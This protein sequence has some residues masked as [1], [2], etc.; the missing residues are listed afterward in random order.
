MFIHYIQVR[1]TRYMISGG[2]RLK[3]VVHVG[4]FHR[5]DDVR[6]LKK[7]CVSLQETG[8]YEIVYIT[9]NRNCNIKTE[10]YNGIKIEVLPII[11]R[12]FIRLF[13]YIKAVYKKILAEKPEVCHIH[14]FVLFPLIKKLSKN[15]IKIILDLHENDVEDRSEQVTKKFGTILGKIFHKLILLYEKKAVLRSDAV[16]SVTPQIIDRVEVYGKPTALIPNYPKIIGN[17]SFKEKHHKEDGEVNVCF[18]GVID[19]IW[20]HENILKAL[21][22]IDNISFLL[23]GRV[24]KQYL[25][26]L[27]KYSAWSK[28]HYYGV[29]SHEDVKKEIYAKS[30]IGLALLKYGTGWLG[31][32][33]TLGNTKLFEYMEAGISIICTDFKIWHEII[34]K[35]NCGIM[36]D[37]NNVEEIKNAIITLAKNPELVK[38]MGENGRRAINRQY[39][40]EIIKLELIKLYEIVLC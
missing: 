23:A 11:N 38:K 19:S 15:D 14:E 35:H 34:K 10:D 5:Y 27:K 1:I 3:K 16:I 4:Y 30:T 7:E 9:S 12:R 17:V 37:P 33:G 39:N 29:I 20:N 18:A 8:K 22:E 2:K 36:V 40:W 28:T 26:K 31:R 13:K 21:G 6:I 32:D 24:E 25:E